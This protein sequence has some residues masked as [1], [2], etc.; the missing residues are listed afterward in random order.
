MTPIPEKTLN[1]PKKIEKKEQGQIL[2]IK[3]KLYFQIQ[4]RRSKNT[5]WIWPQT[6]K[7]PTKTKKSIKAQNEAK[8]KT[9]RYIFWAVS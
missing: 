7:R 1:G 5:H 2:D 9:M 4:N 3:F 6:L 8:L